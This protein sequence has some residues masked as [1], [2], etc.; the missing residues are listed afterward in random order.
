MI[1]YRTNAQKQEKRTKQDLDRRLNDVKGQTEKLKQELLSL[2]NG[3]YRD[4]DDYSSDDEQNQ[5]EEYDSE[6]DEE[7]RVVRLAKQRAKFG[8]GQGLA[9][10]LESAEEGLLKLQEE[11]K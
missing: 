11:E 1:Q 9:A 4:A 7:A 6:E 2:Q 8:L 3:T 10:K 5:E